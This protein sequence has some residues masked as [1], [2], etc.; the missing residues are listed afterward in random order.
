MTNRFELGAFVRWTLPGSPPDEGYVAGAMAYAPDRSVLLV[1]T[2]QAVGMPINACWLDE[3]GPADVAKAKALRARYLDRF[4]R[5]F[6]AR[7]GADLL[8]AEAE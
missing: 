4:E 3:A 5:D 7:T 6:R 8:L 2:D 1:A